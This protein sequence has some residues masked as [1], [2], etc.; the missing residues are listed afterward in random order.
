MLNTGLG[1]SD[2]FEL[3]TLR[4]LEKSDRKSKHYKEVL[5]NFK[6]KVLFCVCLCFITKGYGAGFA[7]SFLCFVSKSYRVK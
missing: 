1:F 2:E 3:E 6:D 5:R 4:Y 7:V